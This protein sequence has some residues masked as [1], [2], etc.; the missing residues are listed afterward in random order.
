MKNK[1]FIVDAFTDRPFCGNPAGVCLTTG[2]LEN[3]LMQSIASELGFSETAF[4]SQNDQSEYYPI[5][6]F[7]P[8]MEIPL[9]G[10]ATLAAAKVLFQ[11]ESQIGPI[12]FTTIEGLDL[13]IQSEGELVVMEFPVYDTFPADTPTAMLSALG[14]GEIVNTVYNE[15]TK[16]LLLE[17][18]DCET[19]Q[20]MAPDYEALVRS[21]QGINGVLVTA[22]SNQEAYDF[23]SRYF[24]PWSG[25]NEDPVTG[26]T[27]TFLSKYWADRLGKNRL[28]SFQC[29][30]RTG[31]MEVELAGNNKVLIRGEAQ[32]VF[33]GV[34]VVD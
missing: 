1:T 24:W 31:S 20:Q 27:H 2:P 12:H 29:S 15:E 9:C 33:E 4:I 6:Y 32:I 28:M 19:L 18:D 17:I 34:F 10:H 25:T 16:I 8:K 26:G 5:R 30:E 3:N 21:H 11:R 13:I 7:S 22:T 14:L 23:E